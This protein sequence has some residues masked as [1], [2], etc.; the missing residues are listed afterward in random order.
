MTET[1]EPG[2]AGA[3]ARFGRYRLL[4]R[5]GRGA[6]G[7]VYAAHDDMMGRPVAVKV[8]MGDLESDP[9]TRARFYREAQAAAGLRHQNII[10]IFDA[11]E[12]E[13]RSYIAMQLLQ[14]WPLATYL[15]QPEAASLDRKLDLMSQVCEGLAA[16]HARGIVHRDLKPGNL[17]VQSDGLLK[18][19]DF[20]IAHLAGSS[21]TATGAVIGTPDYMSPE[22]ARGAQ[23]DERSDIFSAGAVFYFI[24]TGRKPFPGP[25]L[26]AVLRQ[27]QFDEPAPLDDASTPPELKRLI[28]QAM[29]KSPSDRPARVQELLAALTR[30]RRTSQVDPP[31]SSS[32]SLE[33]QQRLAREERRRRLLLQQSIDRAALAIDEGRF[34]EAEIAIRQAET[35]DPTV[36]AVRQL[37]IEL[38]DARGPATGSG[39]ARSRADDAIL[40]ARSMFRRGR[41][42]D[43]IAYLRQLTEVQ[44]VTEA[45]AEAARLDAL[46]GRI[47]L[48]QQM[49]RQLVLESLQSAERHIRGGDHL[50]A[51]AD[52]R[53]A[54]RCDPSDLDACALLDELLERDLEASLE[55]ARQRS[56]EQR[57][58]DAE[59]MLAAAREAQARGYVSTALATALCAARIAPHRADIVQLIEE[60]RSIAAA[61]DERV[62]EL[63]EEPFVTQ[64]F[65]AAAAAV[66]GAGQPPRPAAPGSRDAGDGGV[67]AHVNQWWLRKRQPG[68]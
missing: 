20:G 31:H 51:L 45:A 62:F 59:P 49:R 33:V 55:A 1:E 17:F 10:T 40:N 37:R 28:T 43:A 61:S 8:L 50:A 53:A 64:P 29:S 25:D 44:G 5:V 66:S 65:A 7:V 12:E 58:G 15:K 46:R 54:V 48:G 26:P 41:Y 4:E 24:L 60:L 3:A 67:L 14:G 42:E 9:E 57:D 2:R 38:A 22:Q 52:V 68:R 21:M 23:V 18:I 34:D 11:G 13:G 56:R 19:L 16:A 36:D 30:V 63:A 39:P 27:L 32:A 47:L 35:L 6:M